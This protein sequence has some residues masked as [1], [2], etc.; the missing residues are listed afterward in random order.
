LSRP[1]APLDVEAVLEKAAQQGVAV[2]L[3]A[4]PKRLD[5]DWRYLM[6]AKELGVR[7]AIGPD[8]HSVNGLDNVFMGWV[9]LER[10]GSKQATFSTREALTMS[11]PS[12]GAGAK[13]DSE[14]RSGPTIAES[15]SGAGNLPASRASVSGRA[16]RAGL[17]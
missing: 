15:G 6:R 2:E 9:W 12:R 3:N 10:A 5:L 8:A 14:S 7:I 1:A 13:R 4:D 17:Q 16:L 11:W